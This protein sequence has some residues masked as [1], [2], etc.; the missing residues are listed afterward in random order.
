MRD[1]DFDEWVKNPELKLLIEE[2]VD[3]GIEPQRWSV[4]EAKPEFEEYIVLKIDTNE[5]EYSISEI[6]TSDDRGTIYDSNGSLIGYLKF[7]PVTR[8]LWGITFQYENEDGNLFRRLLEGSSKIGFPYFSSQ[9]E[10]F[11]WITTNDIKKYVSDG[12][13]SERCTLP[14]AKLI[15]TWI[16]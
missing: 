3:N 6:T 14:M 8:E 13:D 16:E 10:A 7:A 4:L 1:F 2:C 12:F 5:M 15:D 11:A 9:R